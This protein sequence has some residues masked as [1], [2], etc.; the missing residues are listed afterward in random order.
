M[1]FL[2][3]IAGL[4][5]LWLGAELVVRASLE[6]SE[7]FKISRVFFGL[8]ILALGTDLPEF[9]VGIN[10]AIQRNLGVETSG[11]V[12]GETLGTVMSQLGLVLALAGFLTVTR[13]KKKT[14][15]RDGV[16]MTSSI[17]IF[18]LLAFNGVLS[19]PEG[20]LMIV[21][22]GLYLLLLVRDESMVEHVRPHITVNV[23]WSIISILGGFALLIAASNLTISNSLELSRYLN[24]STALVGAL[25]VGIGTSLPEIATTISAVRRK[26]SDMAIAGVLGSNIMDLLLTTGVATTIS[27][28][29][30]EPRLLYFDLPVL[31][32][33]ALVI[34]LMVYRSGKVSKKEAIVSLAFSLLYFVPLIY[35]F[36]Q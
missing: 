14:F 19:R 23:A 26:S 32:I 17:A 36:F 8:T 30:V 6:L 1:N 27:T 12:L 35:A 4:I 31:F 20:I 24:V 34:V 11:L 2:F 21:L 7:R 25:I 5:G 3:L 33:S 16:I 13:V 28:F 18:F 9:V 15:L 22:Y 29:I 10:A